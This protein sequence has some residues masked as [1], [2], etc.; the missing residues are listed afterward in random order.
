MFKDQKVD[1]EAELRKVEERF[2]ADFKPSADTLLSALE[3]IWENKY[4]GVEVKSE[5]LVINLPLEGV[6]DVRLF[7]SD[8]MNQLRL[9][10]RDRLPGCPESSWDKLT[11][12]GVDD[13]ANHVEQTKEV[14]GMTSDVEDIQEDVEDRSG[15]PLEDLEVREYESTWPS[16]SVGF[17]GMA[18]ASM[19]K[20]VTHACRGESGW[21]VYHGGKFA[22]HVE[23]ASDQFL[24]D[25]E[26]GELVGQVEFEEK[27]R[28]EYER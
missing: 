9:Q 24:E 22:Y 25:L 3:K 18:G 16:T 13:I 19:T 20:A 5:E 7:F 23:E 14:L 11:L 26:E 27:A 2:Q 4:K 6:K 12:T 1:V 28:E 15:E 17:G 8:E 21:Y 10:Q